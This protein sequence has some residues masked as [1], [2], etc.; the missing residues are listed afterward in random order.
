MINN[1]D[2]WL[3]P[4]EENIVYENYCLSYK[5]P[6]EHKKAKTIKIKII[7]GIDSSNDTYNTKVD[8]FSIIY[9]E[10]GNV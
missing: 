3:Y 1:D 5:F 8:S 9:R 4:V 7:S 6:K 10:R 2:K